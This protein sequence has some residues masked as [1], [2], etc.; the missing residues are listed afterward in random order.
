MAH[1]IPA[2]IPRSETCRVS[3]DRDQISLSD[4]TVGQDIVEV[5]PEELFRDGR[6]ILE[7]HA[8]RIQARI[9]PAIARRLCDREAYRAA[10]PTFGQAMSPRLRPAALPVQPVRAQRTLQCAPE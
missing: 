10:Q 3:D 1:R 9:Q 8:V 6:Q 7:P 4:C 5:G 2:Q